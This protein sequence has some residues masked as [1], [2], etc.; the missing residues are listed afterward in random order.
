MASPL[1]Q[2]LSTLILLV[3]CG[4]RNQSAP[5]I[6]SNNDS[7]FIMFQQIDSV[8]KF[9]TYSEA[10]YQKL[11]NLADRIKPYCDNFQGTDK[12]K[13]PEIYNF[14]ADMLRR[15]CYLENGQPYTIKGC[16]YKDELI[17]CC[18]K[19]IPISRKIGDT[20]S[21]NYTNSLHFLADAYEQTGRIDDAMKLR[22]KFLEKYRKMFNEMSDMTAFAYYEIGKTYETSG[23]IKSANVYFEK[24]LSLQKVIESKYLTENID[25]IRAFQKRYKSQLK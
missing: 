20:L 14:C 15:R 3:S 16:K 10:D 17:D 8:K 1:V 5:E 25:S 21:L 2:I 4:Q 6:K 12:S 9:Y 24:V 13:L 22:F 18:L 11:Y 19:A 23:N 7:V